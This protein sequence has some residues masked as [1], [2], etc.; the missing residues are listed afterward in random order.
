ML[1]PPAKALKQLQ[2]FLQICPWYRRFIQNFAQPSRL[3]SNLTNKD[4]LWHCSAKE[5]N[6]FQSLKQCLISS[7][8]LKQADDMKTVTIRTDASIYTFGAVLLQ[9]KDADEH[10]INTLE[11]C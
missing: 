6:A 5:E 2:S 11:D 7:P 8:I 1:I 3:L 9:D 4:A 10:P